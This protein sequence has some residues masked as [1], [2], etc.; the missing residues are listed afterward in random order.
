MQRMS[1]PANTHGLRKVDSAHDSVNG[2]GPKRGMILPFQ[3]LAMSF[4]TVNYYVD[5]PA[6][7]I[8]SLF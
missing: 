7:K 6:V 5:M 4:D 1:N 3:P 8:Q 2:V